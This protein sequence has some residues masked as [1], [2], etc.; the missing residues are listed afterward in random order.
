VADVLLCCIIFLKYLDEW[1]ISDSGGS[2]T[3]K[4]TIMVP[5]NFVNLQ[6]TLARK[7]FHEILYESW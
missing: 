7:M 3:L 1:R 6:L 2:I 5:N 4:S